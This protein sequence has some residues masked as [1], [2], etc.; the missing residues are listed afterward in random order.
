MFDKNTSCEMRVVF[1]LLAIF[2]LFTLIFGKFFA[3]VGLLVTGFVAATGICLG[4]KILGPI[5]CKKSVID[6]MEN[7]TDEVKDAAGEAVDKA[8]NVADDVV[9]KA[10]NVADDVADSVKDKTSK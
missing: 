2:F 3:V 6:A 1:A 9:D 4:A 5:F 10:K 7:L 8:K